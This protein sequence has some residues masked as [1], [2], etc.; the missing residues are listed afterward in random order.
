[1]IGRQITL[2]EMIEDCERE[3]K[4]KELLTNKEEENEGIS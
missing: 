1:M 2:L 3:E 4:Y